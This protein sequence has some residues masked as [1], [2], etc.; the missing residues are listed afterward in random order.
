MANYNHSNG[1]LHQRMYQDERHLLSSYRNC[2]TES[3]TRSL[4]PVAKRPQSPN[5]PGD[6]D[7]PQRTMVLP[8]TLTSLSSVSGHPMTHFAPHNPMLSFLHPYMYPAA[9]DP[10]VCAETIAR[11]QGLALSSEVERQQQQ[12]PG[13]SPSAASSSAGITPAA[14]QGFMYPLAANPAY[15]MGARGSQTPGLG[16]ADIPM[17]FPSQIAAYGANMLPGQV[18]ALGG[19][20][21]QEKRLYESLPGIAQS[22]PAHLLT[23]PY[24]KGFCAPTAVAASASGLDASAAKEAAAVAAAAGVA[25][26]SVPGCS[27]EFLLKYQEALANEAMK[28]KGILSPQQSSASPAPRP[29]TSPEASKKPPLIAP[30]PFSVPFP[31]AYLTNPT[32]PLSKSPAPERKVST[33]TLGP[34]KNGTGIPPSHHQQQ[35]DAA[36]RAA[37]ERELLYAANNHE[38]AM[39]MNGDDARRRLMALA[40]R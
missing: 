23:H 35:Q 6:N 28:M 13:S 20:S 32:G 26:P 10:A 3:P 39:N 37:R 4:S 22:T 27:V 21:E 24:F 18:P 14:L 8:H 29:S 34:I 12:S 31:P 36:A 16:L 40:Q 38:L 17:L 1:V 33:P 11:Q 2:S 7:Q 30:Y 15:F 9:F 5:N 19:L 25:M